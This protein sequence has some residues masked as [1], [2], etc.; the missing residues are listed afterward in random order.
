MGWSNATDLFIFNLLAS[1]GLE[2]PVKIGENEEN[3]CRQLK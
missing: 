2:N 3:L 1:L